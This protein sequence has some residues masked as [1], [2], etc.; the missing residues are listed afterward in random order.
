MLRCLSLVSV[1]AVVLGVAAVV[2]PPRARRIVNRTRRRR[3]SLRRPELMPIRTLT[4][5]AGF[6]TS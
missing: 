2:S 5:H 3:R 4:Y 1:V 6:S